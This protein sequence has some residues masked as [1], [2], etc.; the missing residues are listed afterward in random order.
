MSAVHFCRSW[1]SCNDHNTKFFLEPP[2]G[3]L[4][5]P[6]PSS[7]VGRISGWFPGPACPSG[8]QPSST[9][10]AQESRR[11]HKSQEMSGRLQLPK[12]NP[13]KSLK[14]PEICA[15]KCRKQGS[16]QGKDWLPTIWLKKKTTKTNP[17][18]FL[19]HNSLNQYFWMDREM[20]KKETKN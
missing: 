18:I 12:A 3:F 15:G 6:L 16:R 2:T 20:T 14:V 4:L 10:R 9:S 1:D 8:D 5:W 7:A 11:G 17:S 13:Q 19:I